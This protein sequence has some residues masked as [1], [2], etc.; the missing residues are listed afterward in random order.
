MLLNVYIEVTLHV[1]SMRLNLGLLLMVM[2]VNTRPI[3]TLPPP[4]YAP[5][6]TFP[7]IGALG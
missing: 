2:T 5:D 1:Y 4:D 6:P 7:F 3:S